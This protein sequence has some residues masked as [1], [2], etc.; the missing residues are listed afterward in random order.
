MSRFQRNKGREGISLGVSLYHRFF[1]QLTIP[2]FS[3]IM[4]I[5]YAPK[6]TNGQ[7][8]SL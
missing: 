3:P 7:A 8:R 5:D 6:K 1:F 2:A 4:S